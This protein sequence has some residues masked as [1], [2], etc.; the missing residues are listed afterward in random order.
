MTSSPNAIPVVFVHGLWLH[1]SSWDPWVTFFADAGFAP[2]APGW[3]GEAA[4]PADTRADASTQ[5]DVGIDAITKHYEEIIT[6]LP[7]SPVVIGHS[8]GGL[9]AQKLH[10]S[11]FARACV[12]IAPAAFR[13]VKKP[14]PLV[15]LK[16]ASPVLAH[17]GLRHKTWAHTADTFH[18]GFASAVDRAESDA[19][20]AE[21]AIP[22]PC[23]PLFEAAFANFQR[24]SP[25]AIDLEG[26]EGPLL[27]MAGGKD[28]T[29]P[30]STVEAGYKV[31]KRSS[32]PTEFKLYPDRGHSLSADHGWQE[33][34]TDALGFLTAHSIDPKA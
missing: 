6:A 30:A 17:P 27:M 25:A 22:S 15:Q 24:H 8:F 34:A 16:T 28:R 10:A 4:T 5:D 11:G 12:A 13:G 32:S 9:I 19:L 2:V 26:R 7:A 29:V 20:F 21:F 18:A 1:A 3:P 33:L 14:P 23:R 31:Q